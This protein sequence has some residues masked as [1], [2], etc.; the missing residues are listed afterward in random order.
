MGEMHRILTA[1]DFANAAVK[2]NVGDAFGLSVMELPQRMNGG[3]APSW[4]ELGD[5]AGI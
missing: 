1:E 5:I 2:I 4:A 3:G